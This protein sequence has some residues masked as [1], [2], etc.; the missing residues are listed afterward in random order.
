[1]DLG[2]SPVD[3]SGAPPARP[4]PGYRTLGKAQIGT[5]GR[6]IGPAYVDKASRRGLRAGEILD[7]EFF[8]SRVRAHFEEVNHLLTDWY[9]LAGHGCG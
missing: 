2:R 7:P 1:M 8:A 9:H 5:T 4:R 3:H 6:G